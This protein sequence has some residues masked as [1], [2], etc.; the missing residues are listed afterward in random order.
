M[1]RVMIAGLG[2]MGLS[3][4]LA[5]HNNSEA[6]IVGLVNR[7]GKVEHAELASY[8][9]FTNFEAAL[10]ECQPDLVVIATYSD[11]HAEFAIAAMKAGAH[12]FVEKPLATNVP[13]A[14]RVVEC[15][16]ETSRKLVVGYILRH[17]PSW[18]RLIEEAHP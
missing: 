8:P 11:S 12:I 9:V 10:Q 13:D 15:A 2:N 3:H 4:A 18:V 16:K 17:H 6:E 7:S 14:K 5:H 1:I